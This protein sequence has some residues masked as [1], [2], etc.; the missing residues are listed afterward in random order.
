MDGHSAMVHVNDRGNA[1]S[2]VALQP[3]AVLA[4]FR[5]LQGTFSFVF[6]TYVQLSVPL[7][8]CVSAG[9]SVKRP[10]PDCF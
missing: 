9:G 1:H 6:C 7:T 2:T 4:L 3:A 10:D 8:Y 5:F